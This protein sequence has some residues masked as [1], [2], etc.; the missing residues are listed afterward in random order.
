MNIVFLKDDRLY[1]AERRVKVPA[2]SRQ[3]A[4]T[5]TADSPVSKPRT[6]GR[7]AIK[8]VDATGAPVRA[9]FALG[10]ID[11]AVY[12]VKADATA[13]PL[14]FFY[15]RNYSRVG[16]TFSREYSFVG[17]SGN[18]QLMLALRKRPYSLADFKADKPAQPQVRKEF[19]DA[20]YWVADVVTDARGEATVQVTYP[21]ALTTW[22]LTARGAT[23]DTRVGQAVARTTVTKDLIVRVITPRF[24]TEGDEV[25]TP[26]I[27]HNYLPGAQRSTSR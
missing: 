8:A 2:V 11:E 10:V 15:Q 17:Y 18:Q 19:P 14:R 27:A 4:V 9:Q 3:L 13:D 6:P 5:I 25:V 22:R 12:G 20:I 21:D 1:R 23:A 26:V 24:L 7:F 16:T